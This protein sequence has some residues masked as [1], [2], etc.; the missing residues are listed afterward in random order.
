MARQDVSPQSRIGIETPKLDEP[1]KP[2]IAP[3]DNHLLISCLGTA[4][5]ESMHK[6]GFPQ[7]RI[8]EDQKVESRTDLTARSMLFDRLL[9]KL[10][11]EPRSAEPTASVRADLFMTVLDK[12]KD[13]KI[14]SDELD[15]APAHLKT[16]ARTVASNF[17]RIA[18]LSNDDWGR[19]KNLSK[20]DL[21][22]FFK[23]TRFKVTRLEGLERTMVAKLSEAME[24][25]D[26]EQFLITLK[27]LHGKPELSRN[28][29]EFLSDM[30]KESG[31]KARVQIKDDD[32]AIL[33]VG[34]T[35]RFRNWKQLKLSSSGSADVDHYPLEWYRANQ[36][37][38]SYSAQNVFK[39]V[40]G[41][42]QGR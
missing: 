14:D 34:N 22:A 41:Y 3:E 39:T 28:V 16:D 21:T 8:E 31:Y 36:G 5:N 24:N 23:S 11:L 29:L 15:N 1:M 10:T 37:R 42:V 19:E 9:P 20:A 25:E 40:S 27:K 13:G 4:G 2:V 6:Q 38:F 18:N 30:I 26:L 35:A 33:V 7:P 12:N 32:T 17:Q